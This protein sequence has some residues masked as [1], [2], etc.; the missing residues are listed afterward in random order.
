MFRNIG[1]LRADF[2]G[3]STFDLRLR[4]IETI[5]KNDI[6]HIPH[7]LF[8]SYKTGDDE[9]RDF[10][11]S[12]IWRACAFREHFERENIK[13]RFEAM[14]FGISRIN[15]ELPAEADRPLVTI[16]IPTKNKFELLRTCIDSILEKTSYL[17]YEIVVVDN[18][19][20]EKDS[21]KYLQSLKRNF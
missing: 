20:D 16:I 18:N 21:I 19:S 10:E 12:L 8:H 17:N 14:P 5:N 11:K 2:Q 6:I 7:I 15:Y 4:C 13:A 3:A 1:W 9:I